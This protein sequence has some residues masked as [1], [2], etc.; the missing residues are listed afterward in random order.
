MKSFSRMHIHFS[1]ISCRYCWNY[2][3]VGSEEHD[4]KKT[5]ENENE[6]NASFRL[7]KSIF[8]NW[9]NEAYKFSFWKLNRARMCFFFE[10]CE[11]FVLEIVITFSSWIFI[12]MFR[13]QFVIRY[14]KCF[15]KIVYLLRVSKV[16]RAKMQMSKTQT[17][18]RKFS[19]WK[20]LSRIQR[21]V[22]S[23]VESNVTAATVLKNTLQ[24]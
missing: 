7:S 21:N 6:G 15:M 9:R 3:G 22:D 11:I 24:E 19:E 12:Q 2:I 5:A 17:G 14:Q 13:H 16:Y 4:E 23:L 8:G 20:Y 1:L 18:P 10:K